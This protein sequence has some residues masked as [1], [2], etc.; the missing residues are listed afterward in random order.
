MSIGA[1]GQRAKRK[2]KRAGDSAW[3]DR[4]ARVGFAGRGLLYLTVAF[5]AVGISRGQ[6]G[7]QADKQGAVRALADTT[8][9]SAILTVLVVG[10]AG[11]ALWQ[12]AEAA[13]GRRDEGDD[14][15]R[16]AKRAASA[17]KALAY[18][19]LAVSTASVLLGSD[20][21]GGGQQES[22]W[23][24]RVFE[25][26][27]GR[28]LVGLAGLVIVGIGGWLLVRGV[29]RKFEKHLD[30]AAMPRR[31][32]TVTAVGGTV[33]HAARGVVAALAGLLLIKAALDYDP[34]QAK[35]IDGTLRTIAEQPYGKLLLILAAVG[36]AAFGLFSFVEAR[37]RRL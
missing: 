34:Q 20:A 23:T 1:A 32:R 11:F 30:T 17:G 24:A 7:G 31:L 6:G 13:Y 16:A 22:T 33:G 37:Y 3:L 5:L 29:R 4:V 19:L 9:G 35:G 28:G 21:Q 2:A 15:K 26:P 27:G 8:Y 36:L 12:A 10:F 18:A 25:L 14:T